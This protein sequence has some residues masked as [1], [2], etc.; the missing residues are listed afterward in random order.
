MREQNSI[1]DEE[2]EIE[3]TKHYS[4]NLRAIKEM[5][6]LVQELR[7]R[8][9]TM[10]LKEQTTY[11][12]VHWMD[13]E[14]TIIL[15]IIIAGAFYPN[16]FTRTSIN[17]TERDRKMYHILNGNDPC[18]TIYFT[19]FNNRHVGEL[20]TR[21]IKELFKDVYI[22]A[23]DIEVRFQPGSEK[24]FVTFKKIMDDEY[25]GSNNRFTVPGKVL[26]EV[27]KGVRMRL[28]KIKTIINVME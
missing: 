8:L 13:R 11:Q 1:R 17:D 4:I 15:K 5:H 28:S 27:Y 20:Y 25:N 21:P 19:N 3:W 16:Y 6:L 14:K 18:R 7:E 22:P 12:R 26:P 2:V 23:K 24:V 10:N 9:A